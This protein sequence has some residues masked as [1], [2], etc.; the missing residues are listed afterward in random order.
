[1]DSSSEDSSLDVPK[2]PY[3]EKI[4]YPNKE[5]IN[6]AEYVNFFDSLFTVNFYEKDQQVLKAYTS[7]LEKAPEDARKEISLDPK[8]ES[9]LHSCI[10]RADVGISNILEIYAPIT[11]TL[12]INLIPILL[13]V[14]LSQKTKIFVEPL[15]VKYYESLR[16]EYSEAI[17]K[18]PMSKA[19]GPLTHQ[20]ISNDEKDWILSLYLFVYNCKVAVA[21]QMSIR[22][23]LW[24]T[25]TVVTGVQ[26]PNPDIRNIEE[27][28][29]TGKYTLKSQIKRDQIVLI[30]Y[31]ISKI[32]RNYGL[33]T[34][35]AIIEVLNYSKQEVIPEGVYLGQYLLD[36]LD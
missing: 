4:V 29:V 12:F 5:P 22:T 24:F 32:P 31:S 27:T 14:F 35:K 30:L 25:V 17:Q 33:D 26:S 21:T 6:E 1:M 7:V 18:F 13:W 11:S 3:I 2:V 9:F 16:S 19:F 10:S 28:H 36:I 34:R 20:P 8:L 15:L 23:F